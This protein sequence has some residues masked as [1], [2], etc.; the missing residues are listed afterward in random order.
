MGA[1]INMAMCQ[2]EIACLP[3]AGMSRQRS[4]DILQIQAVMLQKSLGKRETGI[5]LLIDVLEHEMIE[6]DLAKLI[7]RHSRIR[8]SSR[9]QNTPEQGCLT[10]A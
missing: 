7:V 1:S 8:E 5:A 10:A 3:A 6:A 4:G 9:Q 2:R